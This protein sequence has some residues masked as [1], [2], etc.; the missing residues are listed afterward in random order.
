MFPFVPTSLVNIVAGL[1]SVRFWHFLL[2]TLTGNFIYF[3]VLA[4]IPSG[5]LAAEL[6]PDILMI[7]LFLFFGLFIAGKKVYNS[8]RKQKEKET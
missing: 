4:L 8:K 1:S 7:L 3:F 6:D 5:L 2:G